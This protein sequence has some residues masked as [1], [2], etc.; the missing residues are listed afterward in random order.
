MIMLM[1]VVILLN[2]G[3]KL[4]LSWISL[5]CLVNNIQALQNHNSATTNNIDVSWFQG[6]WL[7]GG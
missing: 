6:V 1:V 3:F 7:V 4:V 5:K 2:N